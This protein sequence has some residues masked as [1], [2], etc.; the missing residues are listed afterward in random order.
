MFDIVNADE[1]EIVDDDVGEE[2]VGGNHF[3]GAVR[4]PKI[5]LNQ[6]RCQ[7]ERAHLCKAYIYKVLGFFS[8]QGNLL[9]CKF[10]VHGVKLSKI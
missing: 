7:G 1:E 5:Q 2:L 3:N 6:P 4:L 9:I 10:E 8:K